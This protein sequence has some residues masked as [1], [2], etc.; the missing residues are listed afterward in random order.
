MG[1]WTSELIDERTVE[2]QDR[3]C[4]RSN[5]RD[6]VKWGLPRLLNMNGAY[7][8]HFIMP[9]SSNNVG[10]LGWSQNFRHLAMGSDRCFGRLRGKS[11]LQ[12][13]LLLFKSGSTQDS[14]HSTIKRL[15]RGWPR[16]WPRAFLITYWPTA[17]ALQPH[18]FRFQWGIDSVVSPPYFSLHITDQRGLFFNNVNTGKG[19]IIST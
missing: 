1:G 4:G 13:S 6:G 7:S 15:W 11:T 18:W 5:Q 2:Q 3:V 10:S 17:S 14:L 9:T 16:P 19:L 8:K 12:R